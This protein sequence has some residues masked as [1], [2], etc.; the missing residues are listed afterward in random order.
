MGEWVP[1]IT[2]D[3]GPLYLAI[4]DALSADIAA[5]VLKDGYRL[6]PQRALAKTLQIDFTTVS[7]AYAEARR[8]GL[9]D[10]RV[11]QGT[12]VKGRVK[13]SARTSYREPPSG[14]VDMAMNLPPRFNDEVLE[15]RLWE[16]VSGL[17]QSNGIDLFLRYQEVGGTRNDREA[18]ADWLADR[19]P[20]LKADR[21]ILAPGAQ[22]ALLAIT[23]MQLTPGSTVAV[24]SL[25]YPGLKALAA[26]MGW[27]LVPVDMD[28]HGL[29]PE[30]FEGVC[31]RHSPAMLYCTPTLH[32]PTT[33][34]LPA[35]RRSA[36]AEIARRHGVFIL[37]D[38]AYGKL[39]ND[40]TP[41]L[42]AL[43]PDITFHIAGLSKCLSPAL[44][45]AYV[46]PPSSR[47][48]SRLIS[49]IR[50]TTSMASPIGAAIATR[51]ITEGLA[52][53]ALHAIWAATEARR[54]IA[55]ELLG[56][57]GLQSAPNAFHAWLPLG[58]G[59]NRSEFAARLRDMGIGVVTS[60]A[61]AVSTPLEA[62]RLGFGPA[63]DLAQ[64]SS[65]IEIIAGLAAEE[66]DLTSLVV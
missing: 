60:D 43:A 59:W 30:S 46:I 1:D 27:R 63:H 51:W 65:S 20:D 8:R 39:S 53:Q 7:R 52:D 54:T 22:G 57:L 28:G 6:P 11:G 66:P 34:T 38:D 42:A 2:R 61:F 37:E 31:V 62:V 12:Y 44:R 36:I 48:T 29:I 16:A 13:Q 9:V 41:P 58:N 32:N 49:A 35:G 50:A 25:T 3:S 5:G 4:A 24:E 18:G 14:I 21:V 40:P 15:A 10:G 55:A 19:I 47:A 26:Q 45:I 64:F 17:Q 23:T 56:P 33:T